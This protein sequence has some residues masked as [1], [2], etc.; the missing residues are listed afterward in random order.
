MAP[1]TTIEP[2]YSVSVEGGILVVT[3]TAR[4]YLDIDDI[5]PSFEALHAAIDALRPGAPSVLIDLRQ[6]VGRNDPSF[7]GLIAPQRRRLLRRFRHV[8][9]LLRSQAGKMQ[10]ARYLRAD[11]FEIPI[12]MSK[13]EA[14]Q[15]AKRLSARR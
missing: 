10:L 3:R 4:R 6:V 12:F 9:I 2:F 1:D 5:E 14:V 8:V 11:G 7:E 15:E 13:T